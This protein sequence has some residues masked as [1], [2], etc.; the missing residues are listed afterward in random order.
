MLTQGDKARSDPQLRFSSLAHVMSEKFLA[1]TWSKLNRRGVAGVDRET[2]DE[3]SSNLE[4][5]IQDL[6][7]RLVNGIY[8][9]PPVRA[10]EI[11]KSNGKFRM[12][13]IPTVED[14]LVQAAVAR[15]LSAVFEP[16]FLDSSYGFRPG[17]VDVKQVVASFF[18]QPP[19]FD[20]IDF[21]G[22]DVR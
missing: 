6:H 10:V 3:F 8:R 16:V 15:L 5:R 2:V 11:P 4:Q 9:A 1:E 19:Q 22:F 14:R 12:L 17:T 7:Q 13:G 18:K 20:L 21:S